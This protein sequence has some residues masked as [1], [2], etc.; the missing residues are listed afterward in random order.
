MIGRQAVVPPPACCLRC[1]CPLLI[2][3]RGDLQSDPFDRA[4]Q[5]RQPRRGRGWRSVRLSDPVL[6]QR[7]PRVRTADVSY[8]RDAIIDEARRAQQRPDVDM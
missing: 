8:N 5:P 4:L 7:T 6:H 3:P 1:A 2:R